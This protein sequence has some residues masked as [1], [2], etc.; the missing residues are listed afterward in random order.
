MIIDLT[1]LIIN[2]VDVLNID[3]SVSY[4]DEQLERVSIRKLKDTNF[5]GK[6]RKLYD[7][8]YELEG[9]LSGVMVLGDDITLEDVDYEFNVSILDNFGEKLDGESDNNLQIINNTLDISEFLWQNI[10]LEIPSKIV[11]E[12]NRHYNLKGNGWRFVTEE[13]LEKEKDNKS[14]FDELDNKF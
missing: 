14:P 8:E 6:I 10:V 12:K 13:E 2:N 1:K 11:N 7:D 3:T 9:V 5:N 4:S